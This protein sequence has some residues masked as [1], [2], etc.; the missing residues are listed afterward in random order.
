MQKWQHG[1]LWQRG[2]EWPLRNG[3]NDPD[4]KQEKD[5]VNGLTFKI[6]LNWFIPLNKV[7]LYE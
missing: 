1:L 3:E 7:G 6:R 4:K 5:K 2:Q